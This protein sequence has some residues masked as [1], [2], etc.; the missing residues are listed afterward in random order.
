MTTKYGITAAQAVVAQEQFDRRLDML[1]QRMAGANLAA[2]AADF[3]VTHMAV[4]Q[5]VRKAK[6]DLALLGVDPAELFAA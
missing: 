3:G 6:R 4:L 2:I 1:K 5:A